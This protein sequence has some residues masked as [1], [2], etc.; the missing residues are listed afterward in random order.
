VWV[1]RKPGGTEDA[2]F[3]ARVRS[4]LEPY[5]PA[6]RG[7]RVLPPVYVGIDVGL[8]VQL[9]R[10]VLPAVAE[11]A[12]RRALGDGPDGVFSPAAFSFGEAVWLSRVVAAAAEVPGVEWVQAVRFARWNAF[13][14][15]DGVAEEL[16]MAPHEVA[17]MHGHPAQPWNGTL[18]LHLMEAP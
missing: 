9:A 2:A 3:L 11:H 1:Q 7:L 15:D 16:C 4:Q 18:T 5:R 6:G 10:R 12:L 8:R 13:G 17:R 14:D